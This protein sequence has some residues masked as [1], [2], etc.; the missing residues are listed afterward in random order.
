MTSLAAKSLRL[1]KEI[2]TLA[3]GMTAD[4]IAMDG[5]PLTDPT[6]V[7]RVLFVMKSGTI[8]KNLVP[9]ATK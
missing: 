4:I 5:N 7:R 8:F 3:P 2:G 6:A 1:D 9:S